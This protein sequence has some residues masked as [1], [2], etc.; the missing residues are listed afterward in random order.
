MTLIKFQITT[1]PD[2]FSPDYEPA[3][4]VGIV[5][6]YP[7]MQSWR[8]VVARR[9]RKLGGR[10]QHSCYLTK[11]VEN[12]LPD[13]MYH[14]ETGYDEIEFYMTKEQCDELIPWLVEFSYQ[15]HQDFDMLRLSDHC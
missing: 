11:E 4:Y 15:R 5:P 2:Q 6:D 10:V 12:W 7:P 9:I 13:G 14:V 1:D 3:T 8:N